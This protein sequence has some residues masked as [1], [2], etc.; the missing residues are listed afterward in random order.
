MV[1]HHNML[2]FF[3]PSLSRVVTVQV[4]RLL[5]TLY[6]DIEDDKHPSDFRYADIDINMQE[7]VPL[8]EIYY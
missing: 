8:E 2:N 5:T 3:K 7:E 1:N 6:P 4:I